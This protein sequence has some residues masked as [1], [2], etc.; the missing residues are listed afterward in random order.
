MTGKTSGTIMPALVLG[1]VGLLVLGVQPA[2]YGAYVHQGLVSE[3]RLGTLAAAEISAI[4]FGSVAGIALLGR[5]RAQVVGLFGITLLILGNL[6]PLGISLFLARGIAGFGA[7][8]VVALGAAQIARQA[9]VN[10]A[11]GW[12]LFLQAISQYAVLQ[13]F[14]ILAPA[15]TAAS[16]QTALAVIALLSCPLLLLVPAQ[17]SMAGEEHSSGLPPLAGWIAL[18]ASGLFVGAAIGV[19]A[20]LGVWL[21]VAGMAAQDVSPRLTA[22]LGGQM[23]GALCAVALGMSRRSSLQVMASGAVMILAVVLLLERGPEG[24]AGW[25]L[26][27][28]FGFAWMVGTPALSGL[29]LELDPGRKSLPYGA[30]AQLLGAAIVPTVTGEL[31]AASGLGYVLAAACAIAGLALLT[32]LAGIAMSPARQ[33]A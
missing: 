9:N 29:L 5:M 28:G 6:L 23:I 13:G 31:L 12:F 2:L 17:L 27:T 4:A 10:A 18:A 14:A 11:S 24:L 19:W 16:I 33:E 1:A 25:L 26:M 30:S 8:M 21:E 7:G 20:Y 22:A 3:P 15:A 32:V